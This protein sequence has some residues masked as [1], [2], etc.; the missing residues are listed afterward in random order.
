MKKLILPL[1]L[2]AS[3]AAAATGP[4]FSLHNTDFVVSLAFL[5]F[6]GVLFYFKVPAMLGTLLDKRAAGIKSDLEEAR[7]L[8][9]EAQTV[10]ASYER[11]HKEMQEQADRIVETAK[12]EAVDAAEQA[13][14]DLKASIARRLRAAEDQLASAEAS[15]IRDVRDRAVSIAVA[16]AGDL[17]AAQMGAA[18]KSALIDGA[19]AHVDEKLH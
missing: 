15:A 14:S 7:R 3:P 8:R 11:K 13:K 12:R 6:V 1:T 4:F 2:A 5:L 18:E 19:I 16:A 17:L 9:E 10:L